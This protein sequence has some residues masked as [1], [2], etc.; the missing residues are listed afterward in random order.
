MN[1]II[2]RNYIKAVHMS[3]IPV[4]RKSVLT[5]DMTGKETELSRELANARPADISKKND[6]TKK[7]LLK[8]ALSSAI[9][10]TAMLLCFLVFLGASGYV[11]S[12]AIQYIEKI[13]QNT[14]ISKGKIDEMLVSVA[15]KSAHGVENAALGQTMENVDI[16]DVSIDH[17]GVYNEYFETKRAGFMGLQRMYPDVWGWIDIPGTKVDYIVMQG[18][19]NNDYL[20]K[21]YNGKYTRYG[22]IFADWRNSRSVLENRN[23][24]L[25]GH[26][27][28][29]ANIMFAPL[30][31]YAV[32][33]DA[34]RN[35]TINII[36]PDGVYTYE[37][38]SIYDTYASYNYIQT[39]FES[40]EEF[41]EFCERCRE[42]SM[43]KKNISFT[44]DSKLLTLSTCTVRRDGMRWALHAVLIG[45]S[46]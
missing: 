18:K 2:D 34:F 39:D 25:Y 31:E 17:S 8:T 23:T 15:S 30:L 40:D 24:I 9:R 7:K 5:T 44:K 26:N 16:G 32:N 46:N 41:I 12:Y 43:Y 35:Q 20:Y 22:S 19:T 1:I 45:V 14:D 27:M 29:T 3:K 36:T 37:L 13:Q 21:E 33:E 11:A 42:K 10:Y 6:I 28:N 38:F 4:N